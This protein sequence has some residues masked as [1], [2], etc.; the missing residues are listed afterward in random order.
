MRLGSV[1]GACL[2]CVTSGCAGVGSGPMRDTLH[3][4]YQEEGE[5]V[6]EQILLGSEDGLCEQQQ[7]LLDGV[8]ALQ[9]GPAVRWPDDWSDHSQVVRYCEDQVA[10]AELEASVYGDDYE[11]GHWRLRIRVWG[12]EVEGV[13][14]GTYVPAGGGTV[15]WLSGD[16]VE[17]V[18]DPY[19]AYQ[20]I[21]YDCADYA[22]SYLDSERSTF[23]IPTT[24]TLEDLHEGLEQSRLTDGELRIEQAGGSLTLTLEGGALADNYGRFQGSLELPET[25]LTRCTLVL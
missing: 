7:E 13:E 16:F 23:A 9:D 11:V 12:P 14:T 6:D 22:S 2:L 5:V 19:A 21:D 4:V 25:G 3:L 17:V 10:R 1:A 18:D 24:P 15:R 20:S 8:E